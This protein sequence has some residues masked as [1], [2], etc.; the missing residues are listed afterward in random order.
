MAPE[1]SFIPED[2]GNEMSSRQKSALETL[3][4]EMKTGRLS[5]ASARRNRSLVRKV[6]DEAF[7][8][9]PE[10]RAQMLK[11]FG[12]TATRNQLG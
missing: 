5:T 8:L 11:V 12:V 7:K 6:L 1:A 10:V 3:N 2:V 9:S 4:Q